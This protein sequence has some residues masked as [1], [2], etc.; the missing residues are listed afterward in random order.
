MIDEPL[1]PMGRKNTRR[2]W[3]IRVTVPLSVL[4]IG[5]VAAAFMINTPPKAKRQ[6]PPRQARL[7]EIITV[8]PASHT[9]HIS[10]M[11]TV[12]A[13]RQSMLYPQVSG[14]IV[15][16]SD[17]LLPGGVVKTGD[18]ILRVDDADYRL[19]VRQKES[20][21]AEAQAALVEE[22]GQQRVARREYEMA[23]QKLDAEDK[24]LV[25]REPKLASAEAVLA[26]ARAALD[27]ARL[28]LKRTRVTA[29]FDGIIASRQVELGTRVS[30]TTPL[31]TLLSTNA[32]WLEVSVP[33][34]QLNWI[35]IPENGGKGSTVRIYNHAAWGDDYRLGEV[36]RLAPALDDNARMAR[37]IVRV[38]DPLALEKAHHGQPKILVNDYLEV[39]IEGRALDG[40]VALPRGLLRNG[41][42]VWLLDAENKLEIRP[43]HAVFRASDQV[44]IDKGL[45]GGERI[46]TS[47]LTAPVSGMALRT[48]DDKPRKGPA[49]GAMKI[50]GKEQRR[51]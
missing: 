24:A 48:G 10:A 3:L 11:G 21:V 14:R 32:F 2:K 20:A 13:A 50:S 44:F 26:N 23:G 27:Q 38:H 30:A 37:L 28:D 5:F 40:V 9:A 16:V 34:S 6:P 49:D 41:D 19:A 47:T 25:L 45:S 29:P 31:L 12:V 4:A 1:A 15:E 42:L 46:V 22:Q 36:L 8:T 39:A 7:V 33:V 17:Q 18:V 35:E 51:P 43:V